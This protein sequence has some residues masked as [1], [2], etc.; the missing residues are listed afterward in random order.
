MLYW[1]M[2][3]IPNFK[4]YCTWRNLNTSVYTCENGRL[5]SQHWIEIIKKEQLVLQTT[6]NKQKRPD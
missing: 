4:I 2:I 3:S 1:I 6:V 5:Y